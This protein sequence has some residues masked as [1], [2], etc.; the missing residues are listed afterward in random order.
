MRMNPLWKYPFAITFY[1]FWGIYL[2]V[3]IYSFPTVD[4]I[5]S[6]VDRVDKDQTAHNVQSDL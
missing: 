5:R 4:D 2:K 6:F 1:D 3:E